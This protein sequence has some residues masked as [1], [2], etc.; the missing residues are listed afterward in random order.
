MDP[1]GQLAVRRPVGLLARSRLARRRFQTAHTPGSGSARIHAA[2]QGDWATTRTLELFCAPHRSPG[3]DGRCLATGSDFRASGER[4]ACIVV[5]RSR[6]SAEPSDTAGDRGASSGIDGFGHGWRRSVGGEVHSTSDDKRRS[7][8]A[9]SHGPRG[10]IHS[11]ASSSRSVSYEFPFRSDTRAAIDRGGSAR[12]SSGSCSAVSREE[13]DA[14]TRSLCGVR[15]NDPTARCERSERAHCSRR[16]RNRRSGTRAT[17][18]ATVALDRTS[19]V[20]GATNFAGGSPA[21]SVSHRK[22]V[23]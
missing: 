3:T 15:A 17:D 19:G 6:A 2:T 10:R 11:S 20:C 4:S 1:V 13:S 9:R 18:S 21:T 5:E 7:S 12:R 14:C 16:R 23:A 8:T 22:G